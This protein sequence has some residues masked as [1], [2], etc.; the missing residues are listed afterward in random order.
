MG[1]LLGAELDSPAPSAVL[2]LLLPPCPAHP[3]VRS[4][5]HHRPL[6]NTLRFLKQVLREGR[7]HEVMGRSRV[8][9]TSRKSEGQGRCKAEAEQTQQKEAVNI[10]EAVNITQAVITM[11]CARRPIAGP[12]GGRR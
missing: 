8:T 10:M 1:L 7:A 4:G 6:K 9:T 11:V 5:R 2:F 3:A 12:L